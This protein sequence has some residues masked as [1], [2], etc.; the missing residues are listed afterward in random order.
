MRKLVRFLLWTAVVLAALI[1]IARYTALR[2]WKVPTNDPY[3][4]ASL[5]PTVR[6]GDW[7]I[8]WRLSKPEYGDLVLCPE[9]DAPHRVVIGRIVGNTGDKVKTGDAGVS[10][11]GRLANTE[12]ACPEFTTVPPNGG[13][14]VTQ[15][16]DEEVL[17]GNAHMRG[18]SAGSKK[19]PKPVE[20]VVEQGKAFLLSDNRLFPYDSRDYGLVDRA[21]CRETVVFRLLGKAGFFDQKSRFTFLR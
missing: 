21:S 18:S 8:L 13:E 6:G 16:C 3:L 12:R 10:V 4:E 9:P 11:N 14:E 1:A 5:A 15:T 2:W 7:I 19:F 17:R 20:R